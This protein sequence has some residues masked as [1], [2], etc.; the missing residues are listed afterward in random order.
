MAGVAQKAWYTDD[1][2]A[3]DRATLESDLSA[4]TSVEDRAERRALCS[5]HSALFLAEKR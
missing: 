5:L 4:G 2:C 1:T 3:E